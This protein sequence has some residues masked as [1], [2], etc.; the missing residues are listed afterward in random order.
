MSRTPQPKDRVRNV[1]TQ[2]RGTVLRVHHSGNAEPVITV[3]Y[4]GRSSVNVNT[5]AASAFEVINEIVLDATRLDDIWN[6]LLTAYYQAHEPGA[7][8]SETAAYYGMARMYAQ[9]TGEEFGTLLG[10]V[11]ADAAE[12]DRS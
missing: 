7:H 11:V 9:F 2:H 5:G 4:D 1:Y 6:S 10:S 8:P 12:G 3:R